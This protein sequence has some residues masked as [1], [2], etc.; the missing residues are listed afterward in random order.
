MSNDPNIDYYS[1]LGV[2]AN[3]THEDIRAAYRVA[4]RR[5]HPDSNPHQGA[6]V[7]FRDIATAYE[8]IG[9]EAR[10]PSYNQLIRRRSGN[11]H[12][13]NSRCIPSKRTL[14]VIGEPHVLY[15]LLEITAAFKGGEQKRSP[16]NL[17]LVLDH[18]SSMKGQRL[19]RLKKAARDT[20]DKLNGN[21]RLSIVAFSDRSD[22]LVKSIPV[23]PKEVT[24]IKA[25]INTISAKGATEIFQGL[26]DGFEQVK[27]NYNR[28]YVNHIVVI[29][30]GYT[31]GDENQSLELANEAK[32]MGI[33]ISAMGIGDEWND[34]FLD[35]LASRTGGTATLIRTPAEIDLFLDELVRSLGDAY[36]ERLALTIAPENDIQIE[37]VFRLAPGAQPLDFSSQPIQLGALT[38]VRPMLV[39]VQLLMP[40]NLE[41]GFRPV[42]RFDITGDVMSDDGR[43]NYRSINDQT[44]EVMPSPPVEDPPPLMIDALGKLTLYRMQQKAEEAI[45]AG[46]PEEATRKLQ[47]LATRLLESGHSQLAEVAYSEAK[48]IEKTKKFSE[49][50]RKT[51]K[52]KTRALS[53]TVLLLPPSA[54]V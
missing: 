31:Y 48:R 13:F 23:E 45:Q 19:D 21:D 14:P 52:F 30:D 40:A 42:L 17:A 35:K 38:S 3:A 22:V 12:H 32:K 1:M 5:F 46:R 47:N 34:A 39:L 9:D 43:I 27:R 24:E 10:R 16:L 15:M 54:G 36:A 50:G 8:I 41:E 37:S 7:L 49:E 25:A 53:N 26:Q 11:I 44:I 29:T 33:G 2:A 4:A 18:S 51:L 28:K 20:V 6:A